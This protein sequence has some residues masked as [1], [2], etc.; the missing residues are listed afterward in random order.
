MNS[1]GRDSAAPALSRGADHTRDH[2]SQVVSDK[3]GFHQHLEVFS[4]KAI[5]KPPSRPCLICFAR[6]SIAELE[7]RARD[8][9]PALWHRRSVVEI[10]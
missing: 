9:R 6:I 4:R 7:I 1:G 2:P 8:C 5:D 3:P 10:G